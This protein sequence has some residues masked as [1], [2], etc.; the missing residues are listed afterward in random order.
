[1]APKRLSARGIVFRK[2]FYP[3]VVFACIV[4]AGLFVTLSSDHLRSRHLWL[5]SPLLLL[6]LYGI[7]N[8]KKLLL[9]LVDEVLDEGDVLLVKKGNCVVRIA[10][11][12]IAEVRTGRFNRARV[13]LLLKGPSVF[14]NEISF[15]RREGLFGFGFLAIEDLSRRIAAKRVP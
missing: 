12:D 9:D 7:W 13:T 6:F 4:L 15:V 8:R 2:R 5:L 11:S 14:G 1:M 3:V 10:L